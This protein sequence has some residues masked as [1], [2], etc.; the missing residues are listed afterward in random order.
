MF[1]IVVDTASA[2]VLIHALPRTA[3]QLAGLFEC[4]ATSD[5]VQR[6]RIG[7]PGAEN[8][9]QAFE[10]TW[11]QLNTGR[12]ARAATRQGPRLTVSLVE[13]SALMAIDKING[14]AA[15]G[16]STP[17]QI[18]FA[19]ATIDVEG[20]AVDQDSRAPAMDV[21]LQWDEG[22]METRT[23]YGIER[24]D[25]AASFNEPAYRFSGF[26]AAIPTSDLGIGRHRLTVLVTSADGRTVKSGATT[27]DIELR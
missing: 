6:I 18:S 11:S 4:C 27:V 25:V 5:R 22:R 15:M 2:G 14:R 9:E 1:Q 26:R 13:G 17:L 23:E 8:F 3:D 20:W 21:R 19:D 16:L 7:G 10:I 24:S 12:W